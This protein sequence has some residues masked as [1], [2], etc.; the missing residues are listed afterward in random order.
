MIIGEFPTSRSFNQ[1]QP[2]RVVAV[3]FVSARKNEARVRAVLPRCFQDIECAISVDRKIDKGRLRRPVMG[4][5]RCGMDY[6]GYVCT[7]LRKEIPQSILIANID[8]VMSIPSDFGLEAS[9]VR[10]GAGFRPEKFSTHVIVNANDL[11]ALNG[12]K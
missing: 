8:I 7:I 3:H 1:R 5:L 10:N 6:G 9:A 11:Q 12:K 4:G 2:I